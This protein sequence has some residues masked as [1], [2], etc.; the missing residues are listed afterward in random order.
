MPVPDEFPIVIN[1]NNAFYGYFDMKNI[2]NSDF[3]SVRR[4]GAA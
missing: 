2:I 3:L 4:P 1:L